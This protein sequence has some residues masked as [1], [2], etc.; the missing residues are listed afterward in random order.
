M[1]NQ[2]LEQAYSLL[3]EQIR[4]L[5][6]NS[7]GISLINHRSAL[8]VALAILGQGLSE[9]N[10]SVEKEQ[11]LSPRENLW[12]KA[13]IEAIPKALHPEIF[14]DRVLG[15]FDLRFRKGAL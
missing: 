9:I 2:K 1:N 5:Y 12:V 11:P 7:V 14:A 8:E 15:E 4:S 10:S 13:C 6:E 3:N